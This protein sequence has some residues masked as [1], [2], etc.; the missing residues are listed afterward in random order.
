MSSTQNLT[1]QRAGKSKALVQARHDTF[2]EGLRTHGCITLAAKTAGISREAAYWRR[3]KNPVYA[4]AWAEA[5][6]LAADRLE[7]EARRRAVDGWDE[8]IFHQGLQVGVVRKYSDR[9]LEVLLR[10]AREK[11]RT[12][13]QELANPPGETLKVEAMTTIELAR[14]VEFLLASVERAVP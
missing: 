13:R 3:G 2:L 8:P 5:L 6:E 9:L 7:M 12:S 1:S 14:R 4:A 10:G 11:F